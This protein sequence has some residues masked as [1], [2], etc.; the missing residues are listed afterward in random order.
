[1]EEEKKL[2]GRNDPWLEQASTLHISVP[3]SLLNAVLRNVDRCIDC[4]VFQILSG[5]H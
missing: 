4:A 2:K 5:N 3:A 1:M